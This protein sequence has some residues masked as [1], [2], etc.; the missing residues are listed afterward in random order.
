[1][2]RSLLS[3]YVLLLGL[4]VG[5]QLIPRN[6]A[7]PSASSSL[8]FLPLSGTGW[9]STAVALGATEAAVA[10]VA[11]I[12]RFDDV[13]HREYTSGQAS[14]ALYA[15]YWGPGKIPTQLVASHTPDRCWTSAGW[16]CTEQI[17]DYVVASGNRSLRSGEG[18][19]FE[20]SGTP[21]QHVVYWHLVGNELYDYGERFNAVP[22]VW[23]WW[24]D[25]AKQVFQAPPEQYF[26]RL[27]STR[28]L[29]KLR[30]DPAF[31]AVTAALAQIGL[32]AGGELKRERASER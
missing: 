12:L 20:A 27:S 16:K 28:P 3:I 21:T 24:R 8:A 25:A 31:Q 22:S 23:R 32:G 6:Q 29:E 14:F 15:A 26:I 19:I 30:E 9:N 11:D 4:S 1:M 5:V 18:R 10:N 7:S 17:H 13:F 2:R